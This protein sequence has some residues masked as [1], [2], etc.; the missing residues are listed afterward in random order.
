MAATYGGAYRA[1]GI[2][3]PSVYLTAC[4]ILADAFIEAPPY[5]RPATKSLQAT[6]EITPSAALSCARRTA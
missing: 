1:F 2:D 4:N 5:S 3:P 6:P